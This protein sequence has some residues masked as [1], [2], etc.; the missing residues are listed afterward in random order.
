MK[1]EKRDKAINIRVTK[2]TRIQLDALSKYRKVSH[3]TIIT[4]LIEEDFIMTKRI[5]KDFEVL[6][7][8]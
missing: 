4:A 3:A 8:E 1:K 6:D 5:Q 2:R 7:N